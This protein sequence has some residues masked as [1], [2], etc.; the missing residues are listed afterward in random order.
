M[1]LYY[2][3]VFA[4]LHLEATGFSSGMCV[5]WPTSPLGHDTMVTMKLDDN[6]PI[7]PFYSRF[8]KSTCLK[9]YLSSW[10]QFG[11]CITSTSLPTLEKHQH[12]WVTPCINWLLRK[13]QGGACYDP[14]VLKIFH[15]PPAK[16]LVDSRGAS[17]ACLY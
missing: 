5:T 4:I 12:F 2:I 8:V 13:K 16:G 9:S 1:F 6:S 17:I 15:C 11:K 3:F 10:Q 7:I 14:A